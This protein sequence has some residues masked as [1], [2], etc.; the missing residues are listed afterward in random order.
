MESTLQKPA[1]IAAKTILRGADTCAGVGV[2]QG[3][4]LRWL[5]HHPR[6]DAHCPLLGGRW[7]GG[8]GVGGG[9]QRAMGAL[10][11]LVAPLVAPPAGHTGERLTAQQL[12]LAEVAGYAE[13]S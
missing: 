11:L 13:R 6:L 5:R 1:L 9:H 10:V 4:R 7:P 2:A 3:V 12:P 8:V